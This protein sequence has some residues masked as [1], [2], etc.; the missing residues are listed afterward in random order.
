[1][2]KSAKALS[3]IHD[4]WTKIMGDEGAVRQMITLDNSYL[5]T[6]KGLPAFNYAMFSTDIYTCS[7]R[8]YPDPQCQRVEGSY[9]WPGEG[10]TSRGT[11]FLQLI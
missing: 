8:N 6:T 9:H 1:L 4:F 11:S 2:A 5:Q 3:G 7:G 10:I